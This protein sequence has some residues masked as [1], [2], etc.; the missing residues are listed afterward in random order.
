MRRTIKALAVAA[1]A[2]L[3]LAAAAPLGTESAPAHADIAWEKICAPDLSECWIE[4]DEGTPGDDN[5]DGVIDE[6][7][8]GWDCRTMGNGICGPEATR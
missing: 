7:E 6:D 4:V 2:A 5:Q 8:S 1:V 3:V